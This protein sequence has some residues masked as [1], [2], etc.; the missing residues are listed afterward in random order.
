MSW[1][2]T[3]VFFMGFSLGMVYVVACNGNSDKN[4]GETGIPGVG[5]ASADE[6]EDTADLLYLIT[7][8]SGQLAEMATALAASEAAIVQ[9]QS[10]TLRWE[11][12]E[13]DCTDDD[14]YLSISNEGIVALSWFWDEGDG[15][16][17]WDEGPLWVH[18][19]NIIADCRQPDEHYIIA[20]GYRR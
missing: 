16:G 20:M 9:L 18:D 10:E 15:G 7:E 3:S 12:V 6:G 2:T 17:N 5:D 8:L 19:G 13:Y 14:D 4:G 11:V 1:K